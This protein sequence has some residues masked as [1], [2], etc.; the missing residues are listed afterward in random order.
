VPLGQGG[1]CGFRA[2]CLQEEAASGPGSFINRMYGTPSKRSIDTELG[3]E[4]LY[5]EPRGLT[6]L[7]M[8][9]CKPK[10]SRAKMWDQIVPD[11]FKPE[12]LTQLLCGL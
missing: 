3:L 11:C 9:R 12:Y 5:T 4:H 7:L 8:Y 6:R 2:L 10:T 1:F